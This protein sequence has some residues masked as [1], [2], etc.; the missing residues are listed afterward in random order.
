MQHEFVLIRTKKAPGALPTKGK[1]ASEAG[2]VGEIR[3]QKPGKS[4]ARTFKLKPGR[5]V[6][7][8]NAPGHYKAGMRGTLTVK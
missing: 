3:E 8:C 7:I 4:G 5:Y 1:E 6:Y 2:A